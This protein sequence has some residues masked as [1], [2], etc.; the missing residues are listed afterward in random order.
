MGASLLALAKSIY[1]Y[2]YKGLVMNRAL[3]TGTN[4]RDAKK[5]TMTN[6]RQISELPAM[7]SFVNKASK[8]Q[9][10]IHC[11]RLP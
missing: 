2:H 7:N 6:M 3:K 10:S 5:H 1:S 11:G 8:I 4:L 9:P